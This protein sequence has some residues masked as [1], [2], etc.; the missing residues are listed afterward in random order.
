[1]DFPLPRLP[2]ESLCQRSLFIDSW[3]LFPLFTCM[4]HLSLLKCQVV[5]LRLTLALACSPGVHK[6]VK[7]GNDHQ[8]VIR[9]LSRVMWLPWYLLT[10]IRAK[11]W[12]ARNPIRVPAAPLSVRMR[13]VR[14]RGVLCDCSDV[15]PDFF[16]PRRE[17]GDTGP[18][19]GSCS[20][21]VH[22][23][24]WRSTCD[25]VYCP[26]LSLI[27]YCF[28]YLK[29]VPPPHRSDQALPSTSFLGRVRGAPGM[30]STLP[31]LCSSKLK[32]LPPQKKL[33]LI[34]WEMLKAGITVLEVRF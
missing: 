6:R 26:F 15:F 32:R 13:S 30:Q 27:C 33:G 4:K 2:A 28:A 1:M 8:G 18:V 3:S 14:R 29:K 21:S 9:N 31:G 20:C 11:K 16:L 5:L 7:T 19:F 23:A 10:L 34:V 22:V 17:T 24:R 12:A 25:R